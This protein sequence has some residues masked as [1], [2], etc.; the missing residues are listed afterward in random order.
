MLEKV[1][2]NFL[3]L[4][5]FILFIQNKYMVFIFL[6]PILYHFN[7]NYFF[8][9]GAQF[10]GFIDLVEI[11]AILM[12]IIVQKNFKKT[13][14]NINL[15]KYQKA[16]IFYIL[17]CILFEIFYAIKLPLVV[18]RYEA[19]YFGIIR[20]S[21]RNIM[22]IY[23]FVTLIKRMNNKT[24]IK[25]LDNSF[26]TFAIIFSVSTMITKSLYLAGIEI[27]IGA[28]FGAGSDLVVRTVGFFGAG[29]ENVLAS[30]LAMLFGYFLANIEKKRSKKSYYIAMAL[31]VFGI[32]NTGSRG[33]LIGLVIIILLF[34]AKNRTRVWNAKILILLITSLVLFYFGDMLINRLLL[35]TADL[36]GEN[37]QYYG[38]YGRI[39]KWEAYMVDIIKHPSYLI[40]GDYLARPSWFRFSPHNVFILV[41]YYGG[42]L[43]F[44]PFV[45]SFIAFFRL[46]NYQ[47]PLSFSAIYILIPLFVMYMELN[48][49]FYF[50]LP[51]L[52]MMS[53]GIEKR[54]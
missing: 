27:G 37:P 30:L 15:R 31:I 26:V 48:T 52:I 49:I 38:L 11:N 41:L 35:R 32:I 53:Y 10:L 2:A 21:L 28:A 44:I 23:A 40:A 24:I 39:F 50:S 17:I 14:S 3:Y 45:K 29:D 5:L 8:S 7:L 19:D 54:E 33:G 43:F 12:I 20:R 34:L 25:I 13:K 1:I 18:S 47:N 22:Y 42:L 51:I 46:K 4:I 16:A 36:Y 6:F 9:L